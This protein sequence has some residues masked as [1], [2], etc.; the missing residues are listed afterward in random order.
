GAAL[1]TALP[2]CAGG[3]APADASSATVSPGTT[4]GTGDPTGSTGATTGSTGDDVETTDAATTDAPPTS[5]TEPG[6][7]SGVDDPPLECGPLTLCG[8][9]CVD[10][11]TDPANCGKCGVSCVI[12]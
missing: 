1:A 5:T 4:P 12:P 8:V 10:L 3:E 9:Q 2:A 6:T 7:T 11:S